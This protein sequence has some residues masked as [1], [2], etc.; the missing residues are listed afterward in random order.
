MRFGPVPL[1]EADGVILA[2]SVVLPGGRLRKGCILGPADI[3]RLRDAG[4]S[5]VMAARPE[6]DDVLEDAAAAR[7]LPDCPC[8]R[9]SPGG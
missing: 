6:P 7:H 1:S 8:R 3:A 5:E 9:P 4:L 2:H